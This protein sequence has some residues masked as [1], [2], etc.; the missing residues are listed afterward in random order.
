MN[1][2]VVLQLTQAVTAHGAAL[3]QNPAQLEQLLSTSASSFP[4]KVKAL[5]ILLDKKAV[6]FLT[7]WSKDT[8]PD[9][10]S[11]EQV[12]E[13]VAAKFEQAKLLNAAAAAWA[14]DAWA[15]ALGLRAE[16]AAA[17][18]RPAEPKAATGLSLAEPEA[19]PV[20]V[21]PAA[22]PALAAAT[23]V[24]AK[25]AGS[26]ANPYAPPAAPVSDPAQ[27]A[28]E[29]AFIPNGRGVAAGR[30]WSWIAEA[31]GLFKESPLIWI[32]NFLVFIFI[33]IAIELVPLIGG[34]VGLL[35]APVLSAGIMIGARAVHQG[36]AL[37][38]G[39]LFAGFRDRTGP[40][41][42]V[43]LLYLV[44]TSVI[45]LAMIMLVGVSVVG[46][47]AGGSL[48]A[49]GA[50]LLLGILVA[51]ALS[52]PLVMAYWFAPALV[53]LNGYTALEAMKTSFSAC[54]KNVMPFLVYGL[55][56]L[57]LAVV[58]T[59]PA[60]LGWFVLAPVF[61]ASMY[62]SYRDIFYDSDQ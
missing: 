28:D 41:V 11:Y 55:V 14:L 22:A 27:E 25:A 13:Q 24:Q 32:V 15:A 6:A 50:G 9:K 56:G 26:T 20:S 4:G 8:R 23:A 57:V 31:W 30:G 52:V 53:A 35:L 10:G 21:K 33:L 47:V 7:N 2:P 36:E 19:T 5:L 59:I 16:A 43:G 46:A 44:G 29:S 12:R 51:A 34:I 1:D 62:T 18:A 61:M 37:E 49:M 48:E 17:P 60:L 54:L 45:V 38:V 58:A 42:I 3:L 40:L 39:H